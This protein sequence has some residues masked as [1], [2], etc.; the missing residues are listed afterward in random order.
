MPWLKSE[1]T[2]PASHSLPLM[3][4]KA[5]QVSRRAAR[6]AA[7]S[8]GGN[9]GTPARDEAF[10][11]RTFVFCIRADGTAFEGELGRVCT[12]WLC[13]MYP[14]Q[15]PSHGV[16]EQVPSE[17]LPDGAAVAYFNAHAFLEDVAVPMRNVGA[18]VRAM[19]EEFISTGAHFD[20]TLQSQFP[21]FRGA[22][23]PG[24]P[25]PEAWSDGGPQSS[26]NPAPAQSGSTP[27]SGRGR[28]LSD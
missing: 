20:E 7:N 2:A 17:L 26:G 5:K 21:L 23:P 9:T 16:W 28:R 19:L 11:G 24:H 12:S 22:P 3:A 8:R 14:T 25:Y 4:P 18:A 15:A 13:A 27:F 1:Y 6:A 10:T